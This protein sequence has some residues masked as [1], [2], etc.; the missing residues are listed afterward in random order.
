MSGDDGKSG[1]GEGKSRHMEVGC[2][3]SSRMTKTR[4]KF[5]LQ[6]IR[7]DMGKE[8]IYERL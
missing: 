5:Q 2:S 4:E 6:E 3:G 1:S 7:V 8:F